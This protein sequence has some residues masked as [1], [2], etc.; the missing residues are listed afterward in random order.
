M[1]IPLKIVIE[2]S[3]PIAFGRYPL[4]LDSLIYWALHDYTGDREKSLEV[5][6]S[7]LKKTDEVF[8]ASQ[9]CAGSKFEIIELGRSRNNNLFVSL[10]APV[11]MPS[12]QVNVSLNTISAFNAF[13]IKSLEFYCVGNKELIN[14]LLKQLNGIGCFSSSG[15]GQINAIKIHEISADYS[16]IK[17]GELNKVLPQSFMAKHGIKAPLNCKIQRARY[18]PPYIDSKSE[19]CLIPFTELRSK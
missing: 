7:V 2:L 11:E 18:A 14:S 19:T 16:F 6:K 17:S 3:S 15:Y 8:H 5:M 13:Q 4:Q 9:A 10:N 1:L 12:N